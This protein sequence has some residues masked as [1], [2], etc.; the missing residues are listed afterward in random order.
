MA[1]SDRMSDAARRAESADQWANVLGMAQLVIS[2]VHA[3]CWSAWAVSRMLTGTWAVW[4]FAWALTVLL[5]LVIL[6]RKAADWRARRGFKRFF[7]T[8][9]EVLKSLAKYKEEQGTTK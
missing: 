3:V 9:N 4:R 2:I 5:V 7:V 1:L 8:S 6:A